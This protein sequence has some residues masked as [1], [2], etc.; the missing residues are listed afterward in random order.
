MVGINLL[1]LKDFYFDF[2]KNEISK[3]T[4]AFTNDMYAVQAESL[5]ID[6]G[7]EGAVISLTQYNFF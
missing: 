2:K 5:L 7:I 3:I 1:M 4:L 6:A